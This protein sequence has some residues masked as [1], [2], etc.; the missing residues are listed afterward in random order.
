MSYPQVR[1]F[2][3]ILFSIYK[4]KPSEI[5]NLM[6]WQHHPHPFIQEIPFFVLCDSDTKEIR[7]RLYFI[8]RYTFLCFYLHGRLNFPL[9]IV[10]FGTAQASRK[11]G[12]MSFIKMNVRCIARCF[13]SFLHSC[14]WLVLRLSRHPHKGTMM[15]E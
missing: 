7:S 13:S 11:M 1:I 8:H 2:A 12:V 14:F 6:M 15:T 4:K 9:G 10:C 5:S 3:P